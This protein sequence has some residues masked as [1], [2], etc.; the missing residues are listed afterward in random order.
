MATKSSLYH[1]VL[2]AMPCPFRDD[3]SIDEDGLRALTEWLLGHDGITGLVPNGHTGE[4]NA[5][6]APRRAEVTR[7]VADQARGRAPVISGLNCEGIAEASEHAAMARDAGV[8]T[9]AETVD[10]FTARLLRARLSADHRAALVAFLDG[11][12]GTS[13]VRAAMSYLEEPL[14]HLLHLIM[15]APEYQ[16]G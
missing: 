11:E 14:R 13:D 2:P 15:S 4:V 5:L 10:Y 12:L 16:L 7:I 9:T 1:G 6:T 8:R 3:L